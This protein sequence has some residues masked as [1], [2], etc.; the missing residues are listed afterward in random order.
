MR[1]LSNRGEYANVLLAAK[2]PCASSAFQALQMATSSIAEAVWCGS[3]AIVDGKIQWSGEEV[4]DSL[5]SIA[6]CGYGR[7]AVTAR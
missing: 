6:A 4:A 5:V 1:G 2:G 3:G 7:R